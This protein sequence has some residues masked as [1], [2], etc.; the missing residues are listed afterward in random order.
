MRHVLGDETYGE[1]S[2]DINSSNTESKLYDLVE[3]NE[4][5]QGYTVAVAKSDIEYSDNATPRL[6]NR[7]NVAGCLLMM[8]A[9]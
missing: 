7:M 6:L 4:L 2:K 9:C 1:L 8:T 5:K 3:F